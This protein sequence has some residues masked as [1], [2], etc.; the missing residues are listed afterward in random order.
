V[1]KPHMHSRDWFEPEKKPTLEQRVVRSAEAALTQQQYV[2]AIDVLTRMGLLAPTHVENWRKGRVDFLEQ[3]IQ[4]NPNKI[5]RSMETFRR[6][7]LEKGLQ[8]S[9]TRYVRSTREGNVDLR[10]SAS[11]DPEIEKSYRTHYVSPDLSETKR[12][13]LVERQSKAPDPVVFEI[14]RDSQCSE[15]GTELPSDSFLYMEGGQP[16]CLACA[17]MGDLEYLPAGDAALTRRATKYS[18]RKAVAV[19]FSRSRG[20]YERQGIL[21][22]PAALE[23]AEQECTLDADAR[24]KA[25]ARGAA[26]RRK[27]DRELIAQMAKQIQAL[28]PVCPPDEA[29]VIAEHTATRGSGRV[30]R[31]AA[32][33]NLEEGALIAAVT[34]A[35][36]HRRTDYDELLMSGM[37]REL[38]R[39]RVADRVREILDAWGE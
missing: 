14:V 37:D 10:F 25:R 31:T 17:R 32:G 36:R 3:M 35:V 2:S 15:C 20:R 22:E 33:R 21:V 19:R 5:S 30:G 28:F 16:L 11:G 38:A 27:Q 34:A 26:S 24:A 13:K 39:R 7:A 1:S 29:H 18:G 12:Q 6:W 23:K 8:P 4:G 9:E